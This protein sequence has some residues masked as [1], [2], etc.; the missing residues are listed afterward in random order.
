M[1]YS[2]SQHCILQE[3]AVNIDD[4]FCIILDGVKTNQEADGICF[5]NEKVIV[6]SLGLSIENMKKIV[7]VI[8]DVINGVLECDRYQREPDALICALNNS[9]GYKLCLA[10]LNHSEFRVLRAI[11]DG[12]GTAISAGQLHRSVKSISS[13]KRSVMRKLKVKSISELHFRLCLVNIF[14]QEG[15]F[16]PVKITYQT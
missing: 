12:Q 10:P 5:L 3:L 14:P 6:A 16:F 4:D 11:V 2:A 15:V 8:D 7:A 1:P 9:T 13:Y